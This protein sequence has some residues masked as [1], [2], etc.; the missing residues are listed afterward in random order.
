VAAYVH[1]TRFE[2]FNETSISTAFWLSKIYRCFINLTLQIS[3]KQS[4]LSLSR[5]FIIILLV[6]KS[7]GVMESNDLKLKDMGQIF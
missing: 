2:Y 4:Y 3:L 5:F 6:E 1:F 7:L